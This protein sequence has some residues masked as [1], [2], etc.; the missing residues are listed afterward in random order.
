MK[1]SKTGAPCD[2]LQAL[3]THFHECII[4]TTSRIIVRT[5]GSKLT[6]SYLALKIEHDA[7]TNSVE[8]TL[9]DAGERLVLTTRTEGAKVKIGAVK[10]GIKQDAV[11]ISYGTTGRWLSQWLG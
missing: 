2:I 10:C 3:V 7:E 5:V 6:V 11:D 4:R 9:S 1:T 8:I